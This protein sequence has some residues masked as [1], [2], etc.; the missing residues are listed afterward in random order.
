VVRL[1]GELL[2]T[3]GE[4]HSLWRNFWAGRTLVYS[5]PAA[6]VAASVP[7]DAAARLLGTTGQGAQALVL[8][9]TPFARFAERTAAI[10]TGDLEGDGRM[11]VAVLLASEVQLLDDAGRLLARFS[12]GELPPAPTPAREPF[13]TV[14]IRDG[15]IEVASAR[16]AEAV[17]LRREGSAL[18]AVTTGMGP[19]LGCGTDGLAAV[20][21]PTV[22]RLRVPSLSSTGPVWGGDVLRG[23]RLLL[24][25]DGT[26][27]WSQAGEGHPRRLEDVGAGAALVDWRDGTWVAASSAAASPAEDQLRLVGDRASLDPVGVPGRILQVCPGALE[28]RTVLLLGVWTPQGGSEVRVVWRRP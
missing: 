16:A 3:A 9:P 8:H 4:M 1:D 2:A 6:A 24:F 13:G 14:C 18:T 10:A 12:L 11:E 17:V 19:T 15:R 26:A 7:A 20:F 21:V 5:G 23:H 28:G 22:A 27:T 25:P